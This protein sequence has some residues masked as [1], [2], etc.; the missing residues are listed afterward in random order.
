[1][2]SLQTVEPHTLELLRKIMSEPLFA[3]TRLVGGTA[4]ALQYGHRQS[5]DLDMFGTLP[6]N[7]DD[8]LQVLSGIG[9]VEVVKVSDR[10]KIYTYPPV[11]V[12]EC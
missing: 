3:D 5:V 9:D 11:R 6:K 12:L 4:L 8:I 1:M 10:I 2:L 7:D